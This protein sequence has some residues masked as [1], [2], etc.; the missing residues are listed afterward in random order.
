MQH[1]QLKNKVAID[2]M[3][4]A[5][6]R[7]AS[8]LKEIES[9]V[10]PGISTWELDAAIED[11]M[12]VLSLKP[13]C[14]GYGSYK[15]AT[16]IS[17]NEV[18]VH[19]IPSKDGILKSGDFVKIDVVG[20]FENYCADMARPF[21]VGSVDNR[22]HKLATVAQ[23]ALDKAIAM[24]KPGIFLS[25]VSACIQNEVEQAG[26]GVVRYFSGH[27]IGKA[28][29]EAPDVPNYGKPGEGP[30]LREGMTLAIEPMITEGTYEIVIM[31]DGWTAKTKDGG[32]AA[33]VE[34]TV[35]VTRDGVEILTRL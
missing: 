7:L 21:F 31:P 10:V 22:V 24:V 6:K 26:F 11:R 4:T 20:S 23:N 17:V 13:V 27:G 9:L 30:L 3:R 12:K 2:K 29:H 32:L 5:G 33:H 19:G 34:D 8:V 35:V 16:C 15:H 25:D 28:L 14:K 18:V 1:I